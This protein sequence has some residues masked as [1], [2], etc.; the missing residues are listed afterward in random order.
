VAK[1]FSPLN[2]GD[3][4]SK[5]PVAPPSHA[6]LSFRRPAIPPAND[7]AQPLGRRLRQHAV[8]LALGL[9]FIMLVWAA[10]A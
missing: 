7:N 9:A 2:G 6:L 8:A 4:G 10:F 5:A 1:G 3:R